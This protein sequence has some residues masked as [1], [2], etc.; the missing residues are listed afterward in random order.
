MNKSKHRGTDFR[1]FLKED[2]ILEDVEARAWKRALALQM[3]KLLADQSL[4]KTE[5]AA[6]MSTS[7]TAVDRL[8]DE[9]NASVTL[10]TLAKAARALGRK[11]KIE[12]EPV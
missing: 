10:A 11:M 4:S 5:M 7:R 3:Q 2:G 8:L 12:L 1:E 9:A 6:R